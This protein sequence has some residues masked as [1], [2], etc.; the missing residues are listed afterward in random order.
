VG[1][2]ENNN[3]EKMARHVGQDGSIK[4]LPLEEQWQQMERWHR[5][6]QTK[7][8]EPDS[9]LASLINAWEF[10]DAEFNPNNEWNIERGAEIRRTNGAPLGAL[11]HFLELG[12]YPPPE[13]L[14]TL[15]DCWNC[16]MENAGHITLEE[17]FLGKPRKSA[18]N[19]AKQ[20]KSRFS[21][22][23]IKLDFVNLL[24]E[25]KSGTEAAEIISQR[26]GG[27][28]DAD[29]LLRVLRGEGPESFGKRKAEN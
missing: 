22:V 21:R 11:A 27:K 3:P 24:S 18:G 12:L 14:L 8:N 28:P 19:Y 26:L 6:L 15:A 9:T 4:P 23:R 25:G 29:S 16:Y 10:M 5:F 1:N 20:R 13:L 7:R 2:S 17:A